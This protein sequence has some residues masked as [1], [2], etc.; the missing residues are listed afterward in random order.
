MLQSYGTAALWAGISVYRFRSGTGEAA[1][2]MVARLF[3]GITPEE[4][5]AA[6]RAAG[7]E[8]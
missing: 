8:G 3:S 6:T 4:K 1:T 7:T 5:I 2:F